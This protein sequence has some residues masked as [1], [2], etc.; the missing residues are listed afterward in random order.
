MNNTKLIHEDVDLVFEEEDHIYYDRHT[1]REF[2]SVTTFLGNY[3][4]KFDKDYWLPRSAKKKG[5]TEEELEAEWD[6]IRDEANEYGTKVHLA[7]EN[8]VLHGLTTNEFPNLLENFEILRKG[9]KHRL[10]PEKRMYDVDTMLAGTTD[11]IEVDVKTKS[12]WIRD[13]KTNV[14]NPIT[15]NAF[16]GRK[17]HYPCHELPDANFYHYALQMSIY[18]YMW[19]K[20]GFDVKCTEIL[21]VHPETYEIEVIPTP[22][23]RDLVVRLFEFREMDLF[24]V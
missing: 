19:E 3:K 11:L 5:V 1:K 2:T 18:G 22:Y 12:V 20:H 8:Y 15:K 14:R 16:M 21:Y 10:L 4:N 6:R 24:G 23:Y 7:L 13:Y 9:Y 17:M